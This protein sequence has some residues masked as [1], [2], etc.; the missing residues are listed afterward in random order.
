MDESNY[1]EFGNYIGE[2]DPDEDFDEVEEPGME[3]ADT[4][5][6]AVPTS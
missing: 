4:A 1:D 2:D 5:S 6:V 3:Y